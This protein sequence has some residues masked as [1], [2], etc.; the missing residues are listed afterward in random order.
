VGQDPEGIYPIKV[1]EDHS[2]T[3]KK[4]GG[5]GGAA[6]SVAC[7]C[8]DPGA[9]S[10]LRHVLWELW[11]LA[12]LTSSCIAFSAWWAGC[13]MCS[14]A[15]STPVAG[16]PGLQT[17]RYPAQASRSWQRRIA[18]MT[19]GEG[20]QQQP[21]P[22]SCLLGAVSC[23]GDAASSCRL[24]PFSSWQAS[25]SS[26]S[27]PAGTSRRS[28]SSR[29]QPACGAGRD[30]QC[31]RNTAA[32]SAAAAAR[33]GERG[34]AGRAGA[35]SRQLHQPAGPDGPGHRRQQAPPAHGPPAT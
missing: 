15:Q 29:D 3:A 2:V 11:Q 31:E 21:L 8:S 1:A 28:S 5:S 23:T 17:H 13:S 22:T 30:P 33:A 35:L 4:G 34:S 9:V 7:T 12:V 27:K 10:G 20:V 19:A 26:T 24:W 14:W 25:A 16:I 18:I 6:E 32:A